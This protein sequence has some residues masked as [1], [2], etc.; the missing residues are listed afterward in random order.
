MKIVSFLLFMECPKVQDR[1]HFHITQSVPNL[2]SFRTDLQRLR[3]ARGKW[4]VTDTR[5]RDGRKT[6]KRQTGNKYK[7][8]HT[9][10]HIYEQLNHL[11]LLQY[12]R[13]RRCASNSRISIEYILGDC[14]LHMEGCSSKQNKDIIKCIYTVRPITNH[15]NEARKI[16]TILKSFV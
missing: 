14:R 5:E 6:G 16:K 15:T 9:H 8:Q 2:I 3:T 7:P 12:V 10:T 11:Y 1:V 13:I 4:K